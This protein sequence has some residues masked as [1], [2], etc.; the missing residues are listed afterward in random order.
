MRRF[1]CTLTAIM[2]FAC[3]V[4]STS[5]DWEVQRQ[6]VGDT[7]IVHTLAGQAWPSGIQLTEDLAIGLLDGPVYLIFGEVSRM[8]EDR[9]GGIYVLDGQVP[10][11]RHF[12]HTGRFLGTIGRAGA[13]PGEYQPLS[14]GLVVDSAGVLYMHDWANS[15]RLVRFAEDGRALDPWPIGSPFL[16]T[17]PGT[18]IYSDGPGRVLVTAG[19]IDDLGL[20]VIVDGQVIDTLAVPQLPGLPEKRGG[21]YRIEEYWSW[22]P[23]GYFVVGVSREYSLEAHRPDGVL[24]IRRDVEESPVHPEEAA[25]WRRRF[26]WME[27]QP[28]Y[29]P[30]EGEWI[31]ATMPPFRG[32]EVGDDGRIWVRRNTD[33]IQIPVEESLG[34][35]PVGW[36]QPFVYDVFEADGTYLGE[37]R[38]P[39]RFEPHVFG[40][41]HVW[42]VRRGEFDEEYLVWLSITGTE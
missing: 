3:G 17:R 27:Q 23:Q 25:A 21:P 24:R 15:P 1:I 9:H 41:G 10:E 16:T 20:L 31:P 12:D 39:E 38:F 34:Q 7:T 8:A 42:G 33:P 13:G 19:E 4:E 26:E 5:M 2:A 37:I 14:L 28:A 11:I 32:L 40:T 22:H 30:P 35:P 29:R 18:W 6:V 36:V